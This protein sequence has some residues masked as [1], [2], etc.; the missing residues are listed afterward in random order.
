MSSDS[1]SCEWGW[2]RSAGALGGAGAAAG[3]AVLLAG[4]NVA[5]HLLRY[6]RPRLQRYAIRIVLL[7]PVYAIGSYVSLTFP[8]VAFYSD[9]VRD[10]YEAYALYN[11]V[12]LCLAYLGGAASLVDRWRAD[13]HAF[14]ASWVW[15]TCCCR[16]ITLN[17][18]FLRRIMQCVLQFVVV[19]LALVVVSI[20]T[21][22]LGVYCDGTLDFSCFYVYGVIIY[23][24][25]ICVALYAL[26][27]FYFSAEYVLKPFNPV[28]KFVMIK[29]VIFVT[30]VQAEIIAILASSGVITAC[31]ESGLD[32]S[33]LVRALQ[34]FLIVLE[35]VLAAALNVFVY[36]STDFRSA[37][38][39]RMGA[40]QAAWHSMGVM[41]ICRD[42]HHTFSTHYREFVDLATEEE[43]LPQAAALP[44][45][46]LG[47]ASGGGSG[48]AEC[49]KANGVGAGATELGTLQ[50]L[51]APSPATSFRSSHSTANSPPRQQAPPTR[52]QQEE[53]DPA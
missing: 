25:S 1:G 35:C 40:G 29:V 4:I 10:V 34:D 31:P 41:D 52:A 18:V 51:R 32:Q 38:G 47:P 13:D 19:K 45:P 3:L 21:H 5:A 27:L 28:G 9:T 15:G 53:P 36:P 11:F 39:R 2:L 8:V 6:E 26:L 48:G 37:R 17:G 46:V 42:T 30:W 43:D 12:A 22:A 24:V 7:V 49:G 20:I 16:R 44:G 23:N 50:T 33:E 14:P